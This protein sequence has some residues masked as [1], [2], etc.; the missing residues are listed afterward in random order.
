[1]NSDFSDENVFEMSVANGGPGFWVRRTTWDATVARVV[2]IGAVTKPAPYYGNPP[3]VMDVYNLK[4]EMR[5]ELAK[6]SVPGT[7]KTWRKIEAPEWSHAIN[8]RS[9]SDPA[10]ASVILRHDRRR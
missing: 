3:V 1:M 8:L 10:I 4:G 6:M 2:G 7:Y 5:E 9:L